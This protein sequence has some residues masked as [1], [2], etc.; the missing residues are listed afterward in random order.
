MRQVRAD[1]SRFTAHLTITLRR[2]QQGAAIG[3]TTVACDLT[4]AQRIERD[5]RRSEL[6]F[7]QLLES[8]PDPMVIADR[9]SHRPGQ[10]AGGEDL[11]VPP[12]ADAEQA[13]RDAHPRPSPDAP[14]RP[15][16]RY[17]AA[18]ANRPMGP[19][20]D[21]WGPRSDGSEF[22]V[23]VS[24]SPME[25]DGGTLVSSAIRD[26]TEQRGLRDELRQRNE[27]LETQYARVQEASRLKSEFL[28]NMSH[29]LRTPLNGIIGFAE[30][31][32]DGK[33]GPVSDDHREYQGDILTSARH[34]LRL[35]NDVLDLAKVE[36]GKME[37]RPETI[38]VGAVVREVCDSMRT[39]VVQKGIELSTAIDPAVA[40]VVTDAGKLKQILYSGISNA[41]KFT[42]HAAAWPSGSRP[43]R[44]VASGWRSR[45]PAS[46][47]APRICPSSSASSS[48]STPARPR[49][50]RAPGWDWP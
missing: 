6:R 44:S 26:I 46:G 50:C 27:E 30:L 24:L 15:P 34:L 14:R 17:L 13:D 43:T 3:F 25:T 33:V 39:L 7:R 36:S 5:L 23:E 41:V 42:P 28:A 9:G 32:H 2:G 8:A 49:R 45:T 4:A 35:I 38:D 47:S 1:G 10:R 22:P 12:R 29:Q 20:L 11:P 21:L 40:T 48:S 19:G 37:L 31:M 16:G 18:P